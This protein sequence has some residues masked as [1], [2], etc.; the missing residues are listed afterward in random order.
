V[1]VLYLTNWFPDPPENGASIRSRALIDALAETHSVSLVSF[2]TDVTPTVTEWS[3]Q[4]NR[5]EVLPQPA[6]RPHSLRSRLGYLSRRPRQFVDTFSPE[7]QSLVSVVATEE[8]PD[9]VVGWGLHMAPYASS[10]EVPYVY[11]MAEFL[12]PPQDGGGPAGRLRAQLAWSKHRS[13]A[14]RFLRRCAACTAA[15]ESEAELVRR[16]EPRTRNVTVVR[17]GIHVPAEPVTASVSNPR[18][19]YPGSVTFHPNLDAVRWF[20]DEVLPLIRRRFPEAR[21]TVTGRVEVEPR[22]EGVDFAGFVDDI[23]RFVGESTLCVVPLREGS[24]TRLKVLEALAVGTPV[25]STPKGIEGLD[26]RAGTEVAIADDAAAFSGAVLRLLEH[27]DE[28]SRLVKA[29]R[30]A[31]AERHSW[32]SITPGFVE[33]IERVAAAT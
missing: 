24:G 6:F 4:L 28:R 14:S 22:F 3:R 1:R 10:L 13:Y 30:E 23:G 2:Q 25:V 7:L 32:S 12:T 31:V 33:L 20:A 5:V 26:L 9:V 19:V 16:I 29:G 27:P 21:L 11:E 17:N 8:R 15:S 18:I